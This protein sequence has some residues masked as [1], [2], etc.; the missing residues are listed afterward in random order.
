MSEKDMKL[1]GIAATKFV[2]KSLSTKADGNESS[3]SGSISIATNVYSGATSSGVYKNSDQVREHYLRQIDQQQHQHHQDSPFTASHRHGQH[4]N[5]SSTTPMFWEERQQMRQLEA[6]GFRTQATRDDRRGTNALV[7][8]AAAA[9]TR[10]P[11]PQAQPSSAS[12][13][14]SSSSTACSAHVALVRVATHALEG[15]ADALEGENKNSN[16]MPEIP[17]DDRAAFAKAVQRAMQALAA[18]K[19]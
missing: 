16:A 9:A 11:M 15:V 14:N 12:S 1:G 6:E 13:S 17:L 10:Q 2:D 18:A 7:E 8:A 4:N 19:S 5:S 3:N